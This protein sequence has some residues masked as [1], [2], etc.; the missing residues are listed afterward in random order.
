MNGEFQS[1]NQGFTI[2]LENAPIEQDEEEERNNEEKLLR[3]KKLV[4]SK[5]KSL[6]RYSYKK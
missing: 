4:R 1:N 2:N 3:A 5:L 6:I